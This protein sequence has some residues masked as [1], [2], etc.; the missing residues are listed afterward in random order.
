MN[1]HFFSVFPGELREY[2]QIRNGQ[3]HSNKSPRLG[4]RGSLMVSSLPQLYTPSI[5]HVLMTAWFDVDTHSVKMSSPSLSM[6]SAKLL[7]ATH[8]LSYN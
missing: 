5:R 7:S 1:G 8:E 4:H 6:D 2:C 3:R